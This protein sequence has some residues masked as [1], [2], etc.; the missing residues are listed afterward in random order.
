M[1]DKKKNWKYTERHNLILGAIADLL[2]E[3]EVRPNV[4]GEHVKVAKLPVF[5][6][7]KEI[8]AKVGFSKAIVERH[9]E[10]IKMDNFKGTAQHYTPAIIASLA[11]TAITTG[12]A[13][14]VK[15]WFQIVED[16][17]EK[18]QVKNEQSGGLTLK[19]TRKIRKSN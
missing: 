10:E 14:E 16:W 1:A 6:T 12:K 9:L 4:K 19:M 11:Q 3:E 2:F 5:P 7:S 8:S 13:P 15:L 18:S 17:E